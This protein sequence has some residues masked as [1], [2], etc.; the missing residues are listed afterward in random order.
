[1]TKTE[2]QP[3]SAKPYRPNDSSK[4]RVSPVFNALALTSSDWPRKLL[5]LAAGSSKGAHA[6]DREDLTPVRCYWQ[7]TA[8]AMK[9][10]ALHP[11]AALL[12][13]LVWNLKVPS[14]GMPKASPT[15]VANRKRLLA[16]DPDA[17]AEALDGLASGRLGRRWYVLEG[18]SYPD[19]FIETPEALILVEG[20]YTEGG[21]TTTTTWMT[22]RHQMLRHLDG[23]WEIKG[24]RSVY[25]LFIVDAGVA[26]APLTVPEK[27]RKAAEATVDPNVLK[28]S[29]PHRQDPADRDRIGRSLVGIT[30]WQAI[31]AAFDLDPTLL[32]AASR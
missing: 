30:T 2:Q 24:K 18:P 3:T 32:I 26:D 8:K 27:W 14:R 4:T 12:E 23:A 31:T 7:N 21:A 9:E 28:T 13:W 29:L 15:T 5:D 11:P 25:G 6:W 1:M 10:Y 22:E 19:V 20:K 17:I 16:Q